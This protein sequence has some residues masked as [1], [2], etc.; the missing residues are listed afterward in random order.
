LVLVLVLIAV[1]VR[2][3]VFIDF[4]SS[5]GKVCSHG[6]NVL[7]R[8]PHDRHRLGASAKDENAGG[9]QDKAGL[10]PLKLFTH[11]KSPSS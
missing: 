3:A 5:V 10:T 6:R 8:H 9:G 1:L 11:P 2:R 4:A 7:I